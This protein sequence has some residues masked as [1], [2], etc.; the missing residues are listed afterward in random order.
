MSNY[1]FII[2]YISIIVLALFIKNYTTKIFFNAFFVILL[3]ILSIMGSD[4]CNNIII[5]YVILFFQIITFFYSINTMQKTIS[6]KV[7]YYIT[8]LMI[9]SCTIFSITLSFGTYYY[10]NGKISIPS[11]SHFITNTGILQYAFNDIFFEL[12][13]IYKSLIYYFKFNSDFVNI[14]QFCIGIALFGIIFENIFS[15]IREFLKYKD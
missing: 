3:N 4:E 9:E 15:I 12:Y 10:E 1:I 2:C 11:L 14:T 13:L 6:K 8:L 7:I 5:L